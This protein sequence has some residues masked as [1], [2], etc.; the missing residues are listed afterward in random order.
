MGMAYIFIAHFVVLNIFTT[1]V[2]ALRIISDEFFMVFY[3]E[4]R[5]KCIF[6]SGRMFHHIFFWQRPCLFLCALHFTRVMI[7]G[8]VFHNLD[9]SAGFLTL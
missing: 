4:F 2:N 6:F 5:E 9:F 8:W 1:L 7:I 3:S